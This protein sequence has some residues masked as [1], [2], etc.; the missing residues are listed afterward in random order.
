[1]TQFIDESSTSDHLKNNFH[2]LS[3]T[4]ED[5][6]LD[7]DE[8]T[9]NQSSVIHN[10]QVNETSVD[11]ELLKILIQFF[12]TFYLN[13]IRNMA[14]SNG[15]SINVK[16]LDIAKDERLIR[17]LD[18][19]AEKFINTM[20]VAFKKVTLH[21][22]PSYHMIKPTLYV[23][24]IELPVIEEIRKLR[25]NHLNKLI[26]IQGVVTRRSAIQ[27]IV[28]IAYYKCGTCKTTT[29][30]YA[31]DT[32]IT[33][34][35]ECQEKGKLFLDNSKTVYKDIQKVTVQEIPGSIPSGSLPRTKEIILTNDLI[36]SCKPGDEID[37]TGIYLNMSLS[38]NKLFPVF[39]TVIKVV[40]L[41]EKKNEN[42]ITDNQIKEI[43]ALSTKENI[44]QLLIKSIAPSIHGYDN[45]KES[46]LLAL[47]GGNQKEKDGTILRGDINVLLLGD[48]STA[49]SQFLRVVQ[50]LSHRSILATGQGASG[51]GLT[52]SVRKDPITKEWVL[53]GG[54]LVL[55]DKGVCC[56]D[57]FDKIN[58]Q[59]RV[60]IHEAMEQQSISISK[61]G[62]V[63]SLHARCSVIAAANPLRGIYNSNLSFNHN[64]NLTDPIIS[65]FDIL[66][67]IKDDVDEIKDKDLANKII[68]NHS[69][70]QLLSNNNS[71]N[72]NNK[73]CDSEIINIKLL[74][75][76]INYSKMNIKPIISTMSIDKISQLYSDLRK[77]SIYSGIPITVRHIESIVRISEA[78]AK[79]RLSL[80]V[81]KEDIDNA[82]RVVLNSFLNAQK[83]SI[84]INMRKKFTKYLESDDDLLLWI[85][86]TL[87]AENKIINIE[88]ESKIAIK[89]DEFKKRVKKINTS[90]NI[91][92]FIKSEKFR[93]EG[94][95]LINDEIIY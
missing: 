61:A 93:N 63:T 72:Y 8:N 60:A 94:Y 56:I 76:Y 75:A 42:E 58:E 3:E 95:K 68:K 87:V 5:D 62:I 26:R 18:I 71:E 14:S 90:M 25:N 64:V 67:V 31:Q 54:A 20:E 65:R 66:C 84:A 52:A 1:M 23:R 16:Y 22:F 37:L 24:I 88:R 9:D 81:N 74:K 77:N 50:L 57:E 44:L 10:T 17:A 13:Q 30:P 38:R 32:K 69:N 83:S 86:K 92:K 49:K 2:D 19:N 82:I 33:V 46:I 48:P 79:L 89:I 6:F 41:V 85:L 36:D 15:E 80:K 59:D 29:G 70:N 7:N 27:N 40:G 73:I 78:F 11:I 55:A 53:E 45:V 4:I 12:N 51:V 47:V 28:E 43:K 35:F 39:N 91:D 34:C 21:H